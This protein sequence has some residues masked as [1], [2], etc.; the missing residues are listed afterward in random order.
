MN[1]Y[2]GGHAPGTGRRGATEFPAGW[3]REQITERLLDVA[4]YPDET[5]RRLANGLW[6]TTGVREGVRIVVL[7]EPA[8]SVRTAF[9]VDGPGV[10]HNPDRAADPDHPSLDDLAAGR[11]SYETSERLAGLTAGVSP[12]RLRRRRSD[13]RRWIVLYRGMCRIIHR[14]S[15][16]RL[17]GDGEADGAECGGGN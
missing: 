14:L 12:R 1:G 13:C 10:V 7:L 6:H 3:S 2:G 15:L 11:A 5:P 17:L 4:R 16:A 9:P 8:G